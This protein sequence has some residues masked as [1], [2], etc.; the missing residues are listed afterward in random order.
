MA[1]E[2]VPSGRQTQMFVNG[3][4]VIEL[5]QSF[6]GLLA[7]PYAGDLASQGP[8]RFPGIGAWIGR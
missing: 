6:D 2:K 1:G 3:V 4:P 5:L 8:Q 7:G